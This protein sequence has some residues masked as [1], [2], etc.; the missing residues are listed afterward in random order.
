MVPLAA[1]CDNIPRVQV[2]FAVCAV[3]VADGDHARQIDRIAQKLHG[4]GDPLADADAVRERSDD[5]MRIR[6]FELVIADIVEDEIVDIPFLCRRGHI[7]HRANQPLDAGLQRLLVLA[8]LRLGEHVL[9][10]EL[11]RI[12]VVGRAAGVAD[13]VEDLGMVQPQLKKERAQLLPCEPRDADR[14]LRVCHA[15]DDGVIRL[16]H[17]A[18]HGGVVI[19]ASLHASL[20]VSGCLLGGSPKHFLYARAKAE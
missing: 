6:L 8:D 19:G 9:R 13:R 4:L 5:L 3:T 14:A 16:L 15:G 7:L 2:F 20:S 11:P 17:R 10:H 1:E 18:G 12:R